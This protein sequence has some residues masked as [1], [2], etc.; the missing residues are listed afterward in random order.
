M[1]VLVSKPFLEQLEGWILLENFTELDRCEFKV[2]EILKNFGRVEAEMLAD[3]DS[4]LWKDAVALACI[5]DLKKLRG[6]IKRADKIYKKRS[7][8]LLTQPAA[9]IECEKESF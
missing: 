6:L 5:R 1:E 9:V 4:F 8:L 3:A 2:A 7:K